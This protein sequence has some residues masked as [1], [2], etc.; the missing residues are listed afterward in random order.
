VY[1]RAVVIRSVWPTA[2]PIRAQGKTVP[3]I[4][5]L[6]TAALA[7]MIVTTFRVAGA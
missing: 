6:R 5:A 1:V 4:S 2:S 3:P 7:P